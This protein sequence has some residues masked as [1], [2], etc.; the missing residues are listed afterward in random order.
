VRSASAALYK[1][2]DS[3]LAVLKAGLERHLAAV[4]E[5]EVNLTDTGIT[6]AVLID[7]LM[8]DGMTVRV[9]ARRVGP[10]K[11]SIIDGDEE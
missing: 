2:F 9:E 7:R 6:T 11:A 1:Y 10:A 8:E 3:K 5:I 4:A